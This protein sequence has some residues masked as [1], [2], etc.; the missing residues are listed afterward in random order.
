MNMWFEKQRLVLWTVLFV[1]LIAAIVTYLVKQDLFSASDNKASDR[2]EKSIVHAAASSSTALVSVIDFGAAGD[3]KTDDYQAIVKAIH[4]AA[5]LKNNG[6]KAAVLLPEA[7]AY[8]SSGTIR[9][10]ANISVIQKA[11]LVYSGNEPKPFLVIGSEN[12]TTTATYSG[13]S[14]YRN[15][16]TDW[17]QDAKGTAVGISIINANSSRIEIDHV[18]NFTIGVETVGIGKGFVYNQ[19]ELGKIVSNQIGLKVTNRKDAAGARGWNNENIYLNGNFAVWSNV[20]G[21]GSRYGV[22][23]T[24][25]DG[26]YVNNNNNVF[27]KPSFELN[28]MSLKS[29]AVESV[30]I[31]IEHGLNNTFEYVRNEG[32]GPYI[33]RI[34]HKSSNNIISVAYGTG[35][36]EDRSEYGNQ[37]LRDTDDQFLAQFQQAYVFPLLERYTA[38]DQAKRFRGLTFLDETGREAGSTTSACLGVERGFVSFERG[39]VALGVKLDSSNVK[40]FVIKRA[41]SEELG[42]RVVIKGFDSQGNPVDGRTAP[43]LRGTSKNSFY[44]SENFGGVYMS[45]ADNSV[46]IYFDVNSNIQTVWVGVTSGTGK[47]RINSIGVYTKHKDF[48]ALLSGLE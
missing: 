1:V 27:L 17:K 41:T 28:E 31:V 11:P 14:V 43:W 13:L 34:L 23:I 20:N 45:A 12:E 42:G 44:Y 40:Q 37:V 19:V 46:P 29:A 9:I 47:A 8:V 26:S 36:I 38:L 6:M 24:S 21:D 48:P 10:P 7:T 4:Q 5:A 18:E 32:N 25:D 22:L 16:S 3:G 30:P 15:A 35:A 39:C 33:A 2:T